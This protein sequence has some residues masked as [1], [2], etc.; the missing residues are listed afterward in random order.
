MIR[1]RFN[2]NQF[3]SNLS[4]D[5]GDRNFLVDIIIKGKSDKYTDNLNVIYHNYET[6][7]DK[8]KTKHMHRKSI[9]QNN[10]ANKLKQNK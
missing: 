6:S 10:S 2:T 3:I 9:K 1:N 5:E 8:S 4:F 7:S